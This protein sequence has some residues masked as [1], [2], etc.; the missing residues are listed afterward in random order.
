MRVPRKFVKAITEFSICFIREAL[1]QK[2]SGQDAV[3]LFGLLPEELTNSFCF[4]DAL[5]S[6]WRY[7]FGSPPITLPGG[8]SIV[9]TTHFQEMRVLVSVMRLARV[10]LAENQL[11]QYVNRL[12]MRKKHPDVL[13]EFQPLQHR[14]NL[15]GI[16]NEVPGEGKKNIDWLIPDDGEP[17]LF[18][19]VKSRV[20]DLLES[21][22]S[23]EFARTLG[24]GEIP[25]PRHNPSIMLRSTVDKFPIRASSQALQCAWIAAHLK[26]EANE[27]RAAF[28]QMAVGR[29]HVVIFGGWS[30]EAS[31]IGNDPEDVQ[32]AAR[33][34]NI[35]PSEQ[36]FF[37]R[38]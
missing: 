13:A 15:Q 25:A 26:Q 6:L 18:V 33:R 32:A 20:K 38:Q 5:T 27:S 35:T 12:G 37:Y 30:K 24:V 4:Q 11:E 8:S 34:L 22:E 16:Q 19:E 7:D 17:P 36:F 2:L 29:I 31:P 28:Q 3:H 23:I 10:V 21:L 1:L 14:T 9:G